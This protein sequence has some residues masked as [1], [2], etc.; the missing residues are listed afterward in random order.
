MTKARFIVHK[1]KKT[2]LWSPYSQK[3]KNIHEFILIE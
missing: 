3:N 1:K 2:I